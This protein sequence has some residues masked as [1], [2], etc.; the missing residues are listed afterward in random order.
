LPLD[1]RPVTYLLVALLVGSTI[2][3]VWQYSESQRLQRENT[4]LKQEVNSTSERLRILQAE[5]N[6][7]Q[8]RIRELEANITKLR[9]QLDEKALRNGAIT[10]GL[11]ILW[12][13]KIIDIN[14][15]RLQEIIDW[16]NNEEWEEY[17]VYYFIYHAQ[18]ADFMP[19]TDKCE[20]T[21]SASLE[22]LEWGS[23]A[24]ALDPEELDVP[25]GLFRHF[26]DRSVAGCC[27]MNSEK[28]A[29]AFQFI[30]IDA[31]LGGV[32]PE[33][34]DGRTDY[35]SILKAANLYTHELLHFWGFSEN[36]LTGIS[37]VGGMLHIPI[38]WLPKIQSAAQP[39]RIPI[40]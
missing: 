21:K 2:S 9:K 32:L 38:A 17:H 15:T 12:S 29:G 1:L 39:Y 24:W 36:D 34:G 16:I 19:E 18:T 20:R 27:Y 37:G 23:R 33:Y 11:T 40:G 31:Y 22:S 14:L 5:L 30:A 6:A 4:E 28:R 35:V 3:G 13:P 10:I 8:T 25:V 7:S 26:D